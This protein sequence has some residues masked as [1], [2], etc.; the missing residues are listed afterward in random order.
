MKISCIILN[1]NL[2]NCSEQTEVVNYISKKLYEIGENISLISYFD[3]SIEK[4]KNI[5]EDNNDIVF[6]IGT[7]QVLFNLGIK[8]NISRLFNEQMQNSDVCYNNLKLYC[9]NHNIPFSMQEENEV[10]L[11]TNSI[12][13]VSKNN[14]N[15]GFIYKKDNSFTIFLPESLD[16][17]K[18]NLDK[19][20]DIINLKKSDNNDFEY[21]TIKCFGILESDIK[22]LIGE[23]FNYSDISIDIVSNDL[24][25][26]IYIKYNAS[27]NYSKVQEYISSII[28]I[29]NKYIYSLDDD[30]VYK[31]AN[32]LLSIQRKN[33]AIGET[34]TLGNITKEMAQI[35][36]QFISSSNIYVNF[37]SIINDLKIDDNVIREY[38][39][40]SVNT[41]YE[42]ANAL[43]D[44]HPNDIVVFVLGDMSNKEN[45]C[46]MTIG[47]ID[48][49]HV[50]KNKINIKNDKTISNLS[51][52]A[53]F[54]LIKKLKHN[55][56][57]FM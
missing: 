47:D 7:S 22:K 38:G 32:D 8:Q 9:E 56:L 20:I 12:P 53:I 10:Q 51:K 36:P 50:Y 37:E 57:H 19:I 17:A 24:D 54:Y 49:I 43:L 14:Y 2:I 18:E 31:M 40:Y 30:S 55:D 13:L 1:S 16:F 39:K 21:Q 11:P 35:S 33:V 45:T 28:S 4:I 6:L 29:L 26:T 3:N 25:N 27:C 5:I 15:N 48:G 44:K 46:F 23:Y 52:T 42:F 34:I 41:V